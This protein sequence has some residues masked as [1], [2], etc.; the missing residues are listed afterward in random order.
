MG[1]SH[2]RV[3]GFAVPTGSGETT[4]PDGGAQP[5]G[6]EGWAAPPHLR[7]RRAPAKELHAAAGLSSLLLTGRPPAV[8]GATDNPGRP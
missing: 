4:K 7:C 2:T 5:A 1:A 3:R 6:L 8:S